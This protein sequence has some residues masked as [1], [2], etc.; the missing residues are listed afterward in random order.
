MGIRNPFVFNVPRKSRRELGGKSPSI[1]PVRFRK[2]RT[3]R[4]VKL[5]SQALSTLL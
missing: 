1:V 4:A 3:S 5:E 2:R